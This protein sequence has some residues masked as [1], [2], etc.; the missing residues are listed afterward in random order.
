MR[1][2][3]VEDDLLMSEVLAEAFESSPIELFHVQSRDGAIDALGGEGPFDLAICDL[4]IPPTDA[5]RD[6]DLAHGLAVCDHIRDTA[7]GTPIIVFSAF[8]TLEVLGK[9]LARAP[10]LDIVGRDEWPLLDHADKDRLD[11]FTDQVLGLAHEIETL[12][13]EI[14]ITWGGAAADLTRLEQ[15][16]IL[17]YA[18]RRAGVIV[19]ARVLAGGRSSARTLRLDVE[20]D[21]AQLASRVLAKINSLEVA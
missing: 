3:L 16:A 6:A 1:V 10:N 19:R 7:P 20:G 13:R 15:R 2:L 8:G 4:R 5:A 17:I 21:A 18:R 14:E 9:R 11:E 12:H